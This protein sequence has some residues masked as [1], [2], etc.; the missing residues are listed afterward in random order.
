MNSF[1]MN[2]NPIN[3]E[4]LVLKLKDNLNSDLRTSLEI[5]GKK[6][7]KMDY[8]IQLSDIILFLMNNLYSASDQLYLINSINKKVSVTDTTYLKFLNLYLKN[9]YQILKKNR[10]FVSKVNLIKK[11]IELYPDDLNMQ[12]KLLLE[13]CE[14]KNLSF[15]DYKFFIKNYYLPEQDEFFNQKRIDKTGKYGYIQ[16]KKKNDFFKTSFEMI[17]APDSFKSVKDDLT[18]KSLSFAA[19]KNNNDLMQKMG[20]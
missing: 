7:P 8:L 11:N 17:E 12:Y 6:K 18:A 14:R 1:F 13:F 10:L 2:K 16:K 19:A 4:G 9:E 20:A 15:D 5:G 3:L